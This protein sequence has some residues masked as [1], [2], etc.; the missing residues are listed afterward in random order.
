MCS[1]PESERHRSLKIEATKD[2]KCITC[3][4]SCGR[5]CKHCLTGTAKDAI[6]S[7]KSA[8]NDDGEITK[9]LLV[10]DR[11]PADDLCVLSATC[12]IKLGLMDNSL[13][14][15]PLSKSKSQ[16]FLQAAALLEKAW[17]HSKPN[18]QISLM[19]VR[20]YTFL[21]CGSLAMRAY[22]RLAL[23]QIQ[24]DTL[25]YVFFDRIS[26]F[27]PK[28]FASHAGESDSDRTPIQHLQRQQKV[29]K[30]AYEQISKNMWLS[31]KNG[32]YNAMYQIQGIEKEL[33][34]GLGSTMSVIESR[35]ICRIT[36]PGT[37]VTAVSHGYNLL[38]ML[39][40]LIPIYKFWY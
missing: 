17:V 37:P 2:H 11:H 18:F 13:G 5:F 20:L 16:Y 29:Y 10:T 22:Q 12:L 24:L 6:Q 21:G 9:H 1:L 19:L 39:Y 23:K 27:H 30:N 28:S 34:C 14:A 32:S 36:S 33:S 15:E 3:G 8:L 40:P 35:R 31:F 26:T 25:S 38:G 4:N 7:Y